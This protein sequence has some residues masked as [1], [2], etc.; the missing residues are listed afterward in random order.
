MQRDRVK[1]T[2]GRGYIQELT[3]SQG[4]EWL[5]ADELHVFIVF[6]E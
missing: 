5:Q 1:H 2:N 3:S 4:G 6:R